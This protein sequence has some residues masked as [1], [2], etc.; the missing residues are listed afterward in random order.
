MTLRPADASH[1]IKIDRTINQTL[2][3]LI[4]L[5][6]AEAKLHMM[7]WTADLAKMAQ[8]SATAASLVR[9]KATR[10]ACQ[11]ALAAMVIWSSRKL[12]TSRSWLY[13]FRATVTLT[14]SAHYLW[15]LLQ[16]IISLLLC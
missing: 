14:T 7:R 10:Q 5:T 1:A 4:N 16:D 6:L 15:E 11:G 12:I 2:M 8:L 13:G 9:A 3:H